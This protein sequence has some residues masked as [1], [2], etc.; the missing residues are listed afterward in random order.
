MFLHLF[1]AV[2]V[3]IT[4]HFTTFLHCV[5]RLLLKMKGKYKKKSTFFKKG[6]KDQKRLTGDDVSSV[7]TPPT[8]WS[9]RLSHDEF[10]RVAQTGPDGYTYT[11]NDH[12]HAPANV[13]LLRPTVPNTPELVVERAAAPEGTG[14]MRLLG[15]DRTIAMFND[16]IQSHSRDNECN[17]LQV[18]LNNEIKVG[19]CWKWTLC[20]STCKFVSKEYKLYEECQSSNRGPKYAAPN[21]GLQ[22][23]LK[24]S[25]IGSTKARLILAATNTPPPARNSM[26]KASRKVGE[27]IC[28]LNDEDMSN[29]IE[30]MKKLNEDRGLPANNPINIQVDGRYNSYVMG[31]RRKPGQNASQVIGI[32]REDMTDDHKILAMYIDNKLCWTGAWLAGKGYDVRCP[33]DHHNCT[34]NVKHCEP[35]GEA[36][37]GY[38]VGKELSLHQVL[39]KHITCDGDSTSSLQ[40][41][42][43]QQDML[44]P[45]W[46]LTRL[47]D[48]NHK[49]QC[50]YRTGL[51]A[52]FSNNMFPA[53]TQAERNECKKSFSAD[54]K[55]RAALVIETLY[56]KHAGDT[57]IITS[58]L[59]NIVDTIIL[60]YQGDCSRCRNMT[61][62]CSGGVTTSWWARSQDLRQSNLHRGDIHMD[63][64]DE[65]FTRVLLEMQ[66]SVQSYKEFKLHTSTQSC[67]AANRSISACLPKNVTFCRDFRARASTAVHR[68]NNNIGNSLHMKLDA[69]GAPITPGSRT[70]KA[71]KKIQHASDYY[72]KYQK[73]LAVK[74]RQA[75]VRARRTKEYYLH[76]KHKKACTDYNKDQLNKNASCTPALIR[77][78]KEQ[79]PK[80]IIKHKDHPYC[81]KS[82]LSDD[83]T[84][85]RPPRPAA[86]KPTKKSPTNKRKPNDD[87]S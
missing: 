17:N 23:G 32:A 61:T 48:R 25:T 87:K 67:E 81:R 74:K 36:R 65:K 42:R 15:R 73:E 76:K 64:E 10:C 28:K 72:Q 84:Y 8:I 6:N 56:K 19:L 69:L 29:R 4:R 53:P 78:S 14:E 18:K 47:A 63:E 39:V 44:M 49:G 1:L 70:A 71:L 31:S 50:Q 26:Q 75:S 80:K 34:A 30:E 7:I 13:K 11:V 21:I 35:L 38:H 82:V 85:G 46:K 52:E 60:C 2:L 40:V 58:K 41:E 51:K 62:M 57:N 68:I 9:K 79:P 12:H 59:Q 54:L 5:I 55:K 24:E 45:N 22:A 77:K 66:L 33:G 27:V 43:A 20:C 3:L 86:R 83:H 37:F 16:F